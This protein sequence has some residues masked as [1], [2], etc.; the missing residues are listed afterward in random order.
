MEDEW[1]RDSRYYLDVFELNWD[2]FNLNLSQNEEVRSQ[3]WWVAT[4]QTLR[5]TV[6]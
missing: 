4:T 6:G 1:D 2:R 5:G 3:S